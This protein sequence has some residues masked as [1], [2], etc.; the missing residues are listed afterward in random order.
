MIL[1]IDRLG[2]ELPPSSDPDPDGAGAVQ[3]LM[4]G[5]AL[6]S[7]DLPR[8]SLSPTWRSVRATT[9]SRAAFTSR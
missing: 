6:L 9:P 5:V 8:R 7:E 2:A 1:R 3:E 4:G